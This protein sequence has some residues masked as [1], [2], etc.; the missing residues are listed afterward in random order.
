MSD[1]LTAD[2]LEARLREIG[3][4]RYHINHPFHRML[5]TGKCTTWASAIQTMVPSD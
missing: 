2:E 4:K 3:A 5:H 1:L